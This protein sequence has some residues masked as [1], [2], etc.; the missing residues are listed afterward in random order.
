MATILIVE[1]D[2][3]FLDLLRMQVA[4]SGYAVRLAE[5]AAVALRCIVETPPDLILLDLNLRYLSGFELLEAVRSDA[6]TYKIPVIIITGRSDD[7]SYSRCR[8]IGM[9]GYFTKPIEGALLIGS[10]RKALRK[11]FTRQANGNEAEVIGA[12]GG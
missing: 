8:K 9:D 10:I 1:D 11:S 7:I 12:F 2:P 3:T 4:N 6:S 5:D